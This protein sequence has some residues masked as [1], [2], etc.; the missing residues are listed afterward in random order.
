MKCPICGNKLIETP[1]SMI[2]TTTVLM[3]LFHKNIQRLQMKHREEDFCNHCNKRFSNQELQN[4]KDAKMLDEDI[5]YW[6][7]TKQFK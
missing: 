7:N 5:E 3:Y 2:S 4:I 6:R 1:I